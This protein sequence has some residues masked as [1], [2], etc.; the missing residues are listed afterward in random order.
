MEITDLTC[1]KR[2][3]G[4]KSIWLRAFVF[5]ILKKEKKNIGKYFI[6]NL[7]LHQAYDSVIVLSNSSW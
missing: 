5:E 6:E 4:T 7:G 1:H 3:F 2:T